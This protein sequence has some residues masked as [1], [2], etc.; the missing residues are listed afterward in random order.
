M[1]NCFNSINLYDIILVS[2]KIERVNGEKIR[3]T[4]RRPAV[5]FLREDGEN[6]VVIAAPLFSSAKDGWI[7]PP[8][9]CFLPGKK[10]LEA[11]IDAG[12]EIE[13]FECNNISS[14]SMF[15]I[16]KSFYVNDGNFK[17]KIGSVDTT[18]QENI[19]VIMNI[20]LD[21]ME[22]NGAG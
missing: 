20:Y 12:C 10:I 3:E 9:Y 14:P 8:R 15:G 1:C 19:R 17:G 11:L 18:D 16:D 13:N 22:K 7:G 21:W 6:G 4:K 2:G 5:V